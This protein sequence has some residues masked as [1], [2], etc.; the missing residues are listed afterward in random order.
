MK[1][2][3]KI[4]VFDRIYQAEL[5]K[6]ILLRNG[7]E[8]YIINARDSLF[9]IGD[10]ELYVKNS[11][12]SKAKA[13]IDE[14]DGL[15][16]INSFIMPRPIELFRDYLAAKGIETVYKKKEESE[17][18]LENYEL[19]VKNEDI[20][21]VI[22]ILRGDQFEGWTKVF[23]YPH[24]RQVRFRY[25]ILEE[26]KIDAVIIKKKDSDYHL[27]EVQIWVKNEDVEK[28]NFLI[29]LLNG[30]IKINTYDKLHRAEIREDFLGKKGIRSMIRKV[31]DELY[32]LLVECH[33]EERAIEI[34]NEYKNW[35]KIHSFET[36]VDAEFYRDLL[37]ENTVRAVVI[38][39]KD[40]S[41]L[42]GE[43]DL[44][45]DEEDVEDAKLVFENYMIQQ[46]ER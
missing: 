10:I 37:E 36:I 32:E 30:W 39:K 35:I 44:Y 22:P 45:V 33:N 40:A 6:D 15:T 19:Y 13:L 38:N 34:I 41:F 14:F 23:T 7:I 4:Q 11:E 3:T 43:I 8:A 29:N 46:R 2:W 17:Y 25:E 24:T 16:K 9:L 28:A 18:I 26:K 31:N 1:D 21:K 20:E 5:C 42:M 12:E 27:E